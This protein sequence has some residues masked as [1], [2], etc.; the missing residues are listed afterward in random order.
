M[1]TITTHT[2]TG[3]MAGSWWRRPAQ[4]RRLSA[5]C[6]VAGVS[7]RCEY[8]DGWWFYHVFDETERLVRWAVLSA[9]LPIQ[10]KEQK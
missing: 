7:M 1:T 10:Q 9:G 8:A 6:K 2:I 5:C 4:L 3:A